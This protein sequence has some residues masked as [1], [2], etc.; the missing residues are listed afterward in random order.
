MAAVTHSKTS[1]A[2]ARP[3]EPRPLAQAAEEPATVPTPSQTHYS[4]GGHPGNGHAPSGPRTMQPVWER[5]SRAAAGAPGGPEPAS[6]NRPITTG[7]V[8]RWLGLAR[9]AF[10]V[11]MVIAGIVGYFGHALWNS[12]AI[13]KP[14]LET[15]LQAVVTNQDTTN[16]AILNRVDNI[17]N[18][19]AMHGR[20]TFTGRR[21]I[22]AAMTS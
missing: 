21:R 16:T 4:N 20:A 8:F 2:E 14:V 10:A 11:L 9:P 18:V 22:L 7:D 1:G 15:Q 3:T 13:N 12:G 19:L 5:G 6:E 17:D